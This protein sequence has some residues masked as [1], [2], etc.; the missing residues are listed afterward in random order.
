MPLISDEISADHPNLLQ[1]LF[2]QLPAAVAVLDV[3]LRV[4][5][6][7]RAFLSYLEQYT[8]TP[9]A[10]VRPGLLFWDLIPGTKAQ[11]L[12]LFPRVLAGETI[13]LEE[14]R[15]E[16]GGVVSYWDTVF[17]PLVD[18]NGVTSIVGIASDATERNANRRALRRAQEQVA[19]REARFALVMEG[20]NDGLWDWDLLTDEVYF[21]PRWKSM[22][23]YNDDEISNQLNSWRERIHPDDLALTDETI[24]MHLAGD[25]PLYKLQHRLRHKD[26]S[27]RWILAR[28]VSL[29][30]SHGT[31]YRM[32]GS[33]TDITELM[34]AEAE[35]RRRADFEK[36]ITTVATNFIN[37][38]ADEVSTGIERALR[39]IGEFT[40]VARCYMFEFADAGS[41]L[42]YN[43]EWCADGVS[44]RL[45]LGEKIP[46][47]RWPWLV[48]RVCALETTNQVLVVDLPAAEQV[49]FR[50]AGVA[51][52]I[53]VPMVSGGQAV[54]FL[55]LDMLK[56]ASPL[57]DA[58]ISLLNIVGETFINALERQRAEH[59][60]RESHRALET[61]VAE[62]THELTTLLAISHHLVST[63]EL[64]PLLGSILEQLRTVVDYT[65]ASVLA[66]DGDSLVVLAYRGPIPQASALQ[67]RFS[68]SVAVA[69]R[70]VI[71]GRSPVLIADVRGDASLAEA[72]RNAAGSELEGTY[73][74][75]RSWLGVPLLLKDQVIGMISLDHREPSFFGQRQAELA[76]AFADQVA[77][78]VEN[79]R[80]YQAE[81]DRLAEAE[82]RREVAEGLRDM[83]AVLNANQ[84][85]D[86]VL[87]H[88]VSQGGRLLGSETGCLYSL[89]PERDLLTVRA[90]QGIDQD[91]LS[92]LSVRM[93]EGAIG[94]AA[95]TGQPVIVRDLAQSGL[96]AVFGGQGFECAAL[97]QLAQF[98]SAVAVPLTIQDG[99]FWSM[100]FFFGTPAGTRTADLGLAMIFADQAALAI[101]NAGLR[102]QLQQVA[103]AAERSRLARDLHDA[104]TQTLFSASLIA[105]VL[106]TI[107]LRNPLEGR[108]RLEELRQLTRG[109][110][111][112]M[113]T[114]L[115]ELRPSALTEA[116]LGDLVK[117][118]CESITGRSRLPVTLKIDGSSDLPPDV[119]IGLYRIAQEA[120]NNVA[121]H[122][123]ASELAVSL[124]LSSEHVDL[125]IRDDGAGFDMAGIPPDHLGLGIMKERAEAIGAGLTIVSE[126]GEGTDVLVN[127]QRK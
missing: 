81:Q 60:L 9:A 123:G 112:E 89:A 48:K 51:S 26:G 50:A 101:E 12:E 76:L 3:D 94:Q 49:D 121:K 28:G 8:R 87:H 108:R 37:L 125:A 52:F 95:K 14:L 65:G 80:L 56:P 38:A 86:A 57:P 64:A 68:L 126:P 61:R 55:G 36:L 69:N 82:R 98:R 105:E 23:G 19:A 77:V 15:M 93:G 59:A 16:S 85:L 106:P 1:V 18:Q 66:V 74:Y 44:S 102:D 17:S 4:Q 39:A 90:A 32:A 103:V 100:V 110:L 53:A 83:L 122:A 7:N 115:L 30:D 118:L 96:A 117:Q 114:L 99:T 79:A 41:T 70:Q 42:Q 10:R 46:V 54:G 91:C 104:V 75:I 33:H 63:L 24:R 20:T 67:L 34:E 58:S 111:A 21:S 88:I 92:Q 25:T 119:Q 47:E 27:Y 109:A 2:N 13:R 107:W 71:E 5:H 11:A 43:Y 84:P 78:A 40:Q 124:T 45:P 127:W 22:I 97:A 6:W 31:P 29:R 113:R 116:N 62:R 73:G 35:L 120:L 72:F